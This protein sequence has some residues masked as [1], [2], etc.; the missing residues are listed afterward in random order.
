M[1]N[2][3]DY[4]QMIQYSLNLFKFN[5]KYNL[6]NELFLSFN[7]LLIQ[8]NYFNNHLLVQSNQLPL[9]EKKYH[10]SNS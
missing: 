4:K 7:D 6:K 2:K 8:F 9:Q 3:N 1:A 10:L 5:L